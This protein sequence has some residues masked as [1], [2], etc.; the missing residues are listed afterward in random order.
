[1]LSALGGTATRVVVNDRLDVALASGAAGVHLREVSV[2]VSRVRVVAPA[3]FLVGRSVHRPEDAASW[4]ADYVVFGTVFPSRS[5]AADEAIAGLDGLQ[6]ALTGSRVPVLA[7]GGI[8]RAELG[9]VAKAG[10]AGVAAIDLFL[11]SG[12]GDDHPLDEIVSAVHAAFDSAGS[13]S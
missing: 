6:R 8:G 2:P 11:P 12:R 9:A 1:M 3:G 7:I 13:V 4:D 10:A 5:K